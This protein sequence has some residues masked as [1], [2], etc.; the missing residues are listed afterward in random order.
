MTSGRKKAFDEETAL[1]AAMHVFWQKGYVGASLADLTDAMAINKPSMYRTFGNK[2]QLFIKTTQR[3]VDTRVSKLVQI[4]HDPTL[5]LMTRLKDYIMAIIA[6]QCHSSP[7]KGCYLVLCQSELSSGTLPSKASEL[8]TSMDNIPTNE[9]TQIFNT[10]PE[11][12]KLGLNQQAEQKALS[13]YT[14]LKGTACMARSGFD[15][16]Q[17]EFAVDN[18]LSGICSQHS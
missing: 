11:A 16:A 3:Y 7:A 10:D 1:D 8:L 15:Q 18:M 17:L 6:M 12:I 2:E 13:I 14:L 5:P 4:L 9:F